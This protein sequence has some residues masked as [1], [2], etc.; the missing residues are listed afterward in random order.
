VWD[1]N[2]IIH[3]NARY[4]LRHDADF[5]VM[6]K[7]PDG[8]MIETPN[9]KAPYAY[10][11]YVINKKTK[12]DKETREE[13]ASSKRC[14]FYLI[15]PMT[16]LSVIKGWGQKIQAADPNFARLIQGASMIPTTRAKPPAPEAPDQSSSSSSPSP[17]SITA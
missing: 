9:N 15:D 17:G 12:A 1:A 5:Y 4:F 6:T 11:F 8:R 7:L 16:V 3:H 10:N 13:W 14:D 2:M